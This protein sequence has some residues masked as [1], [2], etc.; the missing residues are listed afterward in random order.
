MLGLVCWV[1][2]LV[3]WSNTWSFSA[4]PGFS[5]QLLAFLSETSSFCIAWYCFQSLFFIATLGRYFFQGLFFLVFGLVFWVYPIPFTFHVVT[6]LLF[7]NLVS[8]TTKTSNHPTARPRPPV[9]PHH[10]HL[11]PHPPTASIPAA[12][13]EQ[14]PTGGGP[15]EG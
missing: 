14:K 9:I 7:F 2:A 4:K 11:H 15:G 5:Q 13:G 8:E 1:F 6:Y 3:F 12:W 10:T